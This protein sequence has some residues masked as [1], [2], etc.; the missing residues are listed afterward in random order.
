MRRVLIALAASALGFALLFAAAPGVDLTVSGWF[1]D[2]AQ[3]F[4]ANQRVV[5]R[6]IYDLVLWGSRAVL[7]VLAIAFLGSWLIRGERVRPWRRRLG[8][9]VLAFLLGP[10]LIV[11]VALKDHW[12]RARPHQIV[13]FGGSKHYTAPL[14][15]AHQCSNN[16]S[17]VSGHAS[18]G[19]ALVA[20]GLLVTGRARRRWFAAGI[21]LGA[22]A[23]AVRIM[24]GGHFLS[25][26]IFAFYFTVLGIAI[27][28]LV[29]RLLRVPLE[30][31]AHEAALSAN[32]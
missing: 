14:T 27:A 20:F 29:F 6:F 31:A 11:D 24:Q 32:S 10:G 2:P 1:Y 26:V 16:C 25:D 4:P 5:V 30:P 21:A 28:A 12:G 13:E 19:F 22:L 7:V 3:G 18:A 9:L 23:G 17:F 15:I 8:F